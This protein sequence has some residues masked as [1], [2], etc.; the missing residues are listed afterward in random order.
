M[1]KCM[2]LPIPAE[3]KGHPPSPTPAHRGPPAPRPAGVQ[4]P[5]QEAFVPRRQDPKKDV[6]IF[7]AIAAADVYDAHR[8]ALIADERARLL[9]GPRK[10]S[11]HAAPWPQTL[12]SPM[13]LGAMLFVVPPIGLAV[14]WTSPRY[15]REARWVLTVTT[16]LMM[17]IATTLAV[18]WLVSRS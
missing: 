10:E 16:A 2:Y 4:R 3:L 15:S 17:C 1:R 9:E 5:P 18:V 13:A 8:R 14:L 6:R 12:D 11:P 7:P